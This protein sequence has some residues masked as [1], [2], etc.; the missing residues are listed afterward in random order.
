MNLTQLQKIFENA[1]DEQLNQINNFYR[2]DKDTIKNLQEENNNLVTQVAEFKEKV[3][4][5]EK[6][7]D[8]S[9]ELQK[10]IQDLKFKM[11]EQEEQYKKEAEERQINDVI[12]DVF[13]DKK[14]INDITKQGYTNKLKEAI[15]DPN[16]KGKSARDL[17]EEM[18]K[19]IDNIFM[20]EQQEKVVIPAVGNVSSNKI[21]TREQ[22]QAMSTDEI[23][24]NWELVS[25]S[26]KE[27]K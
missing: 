1:T 22:I 3:T 17:F 25:N 21:L 27:V 20:N 16:N 15:L 6:N 26:L 8:N 18:T 13:V 5:L 24:K 9:E 4:E 2:K 7:Q 14:F 19:D 23:N 10:T 11:K 12:A